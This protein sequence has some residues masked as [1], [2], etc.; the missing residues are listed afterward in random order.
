MWFKTYPQFDNSLIILSENENDLNDFKIYND[1]L[2]DH[3]DHGFLELWKKNDIVIEKLKRLVNLLHHLCEL[4]TKKK[5]Y[6]NIEIEFIPINYFKYKFDTYNHY[7][8]NIKK[9]KKSIELC[10]YVINEYCF[11]LY[12]ELYPE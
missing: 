1:Y 7:K 9:I 8:M 6:S 10:N 3:H 4:F 11:D 2:I 12:D 5:L